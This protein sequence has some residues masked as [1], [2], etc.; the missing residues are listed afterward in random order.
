VEIF[1]LAT[2]LAGE[3]NRPNA[4]PR[5]NVTAVDL[6]GLEPSLVLLRLIS[7]PFP[8]MASEIGL[9]GNAAHSGSTNPP[10]APCIALSSWCLATVVIHADDDAD[11]GAA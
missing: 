7:G 9:T 8:A 1:L 11:V 2:S 10:C 6:D 5:F 3:E 4:L